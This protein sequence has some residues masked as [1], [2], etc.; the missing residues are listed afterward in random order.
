M[1]LDFV[2][3]FELVYPGEPHLPF[4]LLLDTSSAMSGEPINNLNKA[5]NN[6]IV[7]VKEDERSTRCIDVA[8]IEFN[9]DVRVVQD[10]FP[11]SRMEP[12][13]LT[14]N[15]GTSMGAGIEL[16][17]KKLKERKLL[18]ANLGIQLYQPWIVMIT[19]SCPTDDITEAA[20]LIKTAEAK[21]TYGEFKF[22]TVGAQGFSLE[23]V[24][25]LSDTK[26]ILKLNK[27]NFDAFFDFLGNGLFCPIW[28]YRDG[29]NIKFDDLPG[30]VKPVTK[31]EL[32]LEW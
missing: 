29:E 13:T 18:Y 11:I 23:H 17:I 19:A 25:K 5:L 8:I 32:P 15:G 6:F 28:V 10:F 20:Q 4:V 3:E 22:W 7:R 9:T 2:P 21:G 24:E 31:N 14:A 12:I 1:P 26:R 30:D 16:A 27:F